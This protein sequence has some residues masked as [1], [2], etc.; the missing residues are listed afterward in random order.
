MAHQIGGLE[1]FA[2][3]LARWAAEAPTTEERRAAA[4]VVGAAR[5][6]LG[7]VRSC[8]AD[9]WQAVADP[10]MLLARGEAGLPGLAELT[11][12]PDW[13]LDGWPGIGALWQASPP[14]GR[15]IALAEIVAV[16]PVPPVEA[17]GWPGPVVDWSVVVRARR[18]LHPRPAWVGGGLVELA[19]RNETLRMLAA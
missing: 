5:L 12:R 9:L 19:A 8:L 7:A 14:S 13:L 1:A 10:A 11:A 6:T 17:D 18:L 15:G 2:A 3:D 4:L 16:L